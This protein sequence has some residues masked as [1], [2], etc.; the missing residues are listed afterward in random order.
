MKQ[1]WKFLPIIDPS[2]LNRLTDVI[3]SSGSSIRRTSLIYVYIHKLDG[4]RCF[5]Y[6][7]LK[8]CASRS[9]VHA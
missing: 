8:S 1:K 6:S 4:G 2:L 3:V 5:S 9:E 7:D